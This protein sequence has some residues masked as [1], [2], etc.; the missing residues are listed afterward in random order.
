MRLVFIQGY[1]SSQTRGPYRVNDLAS[2]DFSGS[3]SFFFNM[4]R[5]VASRGH[6]VE[7][8][9]FW[10]SEH[11]DGSIHYVPFNITQESSNC[12]LVHPPEKYDAV[13]SWNE[14]DYLSIFPESVKR[15]CVQQLNDF[16]YCNTDF[17][18]FT[19]LY[20][21]P[22]KRHMEHI[23]VRSGLPAEK[24]AVLSN[25]ISNEDNFLGPEDHDNHKIVYCS[26]PDRGLHWLCDLFP[27]LKAEVPDA[28]LH[29]YYRIDTWLNRFNS[30]WSP[31]PAYQEL[32][33]R[34]RYVTDFIRRWGEGKGV[35]FH[36]GVS[37]GEMAKALKTSRLLAYP[38]DTVCFTEGFGVSVL[39]A[40]TAGAYPLISDVD[41]FGSVYGG[42]AH[43]IP[44]RPADKKKEWV[45]AM[46]YALTDDDL[47]EDLTKGTREFSKKFTRASR[48][49]ALLSFIEAGVA[50]AAA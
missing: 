31:D 40:C 24:C 22:S 30:A 35:F 23:I 16:D 2:H 5:E 10:T 48:A 37:N 1:F 46:Q 14:P 32:G 12:H 11:R 29:V 13:V 25:C 3:E 15:I 21:L 45:D 9:G 18:K 28:E 50:C 41:A 49:D 44:G 6:E 4:V 34:S 20:L 17:K 39:D 33:F 26:S 19:D 43:V 47:F 36:G 8:H 38:C 42:H 27:K 7:A